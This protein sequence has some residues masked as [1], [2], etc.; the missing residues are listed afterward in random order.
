MNISNLNSLSIIPVV[1]Y[2]NAFSNKN[3]IILD[4]KEKAGIYCWTLLSSGKSYVGSSINLGRR[5]R[6]YFNPIYISHFTRKNMVINK[7]LLKYGYSKFKLEILEYCDPEDLIKKEQ[8]YM[9]ILNPEY[10]VLN[11]AYSSLGYKHTINL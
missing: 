8:Y 5:L 4:N 7:A 10:N 2:N 11:T 3:Q 1:T 6:D 9:D